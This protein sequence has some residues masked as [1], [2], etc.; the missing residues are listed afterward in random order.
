MSDH[1][2]LGSFEEWR[3]S[4]LEARVL[5]GLSRSLETTGKDDMLFR[6]ARAH[7]LLERNASE[8][9]RPQS[10][11]GCRSPLELL[12]LALRRA[13]EAHLVPE[14]AEF[15]LLRARWANRLSNQTPL[16][17]ARAGMHD[18]ALTLAATGDDQRTNLWYL[19]LAWEYADTGNLGQAR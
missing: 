6:F 9:A 15:L 17:A 7:R 1:R 16:D 11:L 2:P 18:R 19:L 10:S 13:V 3:S 5:S 12:D 4:G 8:N 14:M